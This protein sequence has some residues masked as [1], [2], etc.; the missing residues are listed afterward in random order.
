MPR[1]PLYMFEDPGWRRFGPLTTLH[2]VW[3][4]RL[5][6]Q[7]LHDL[8][9]HLVDQVP[10]GY[11]PR[12]ALQPLVALD[13]QKPT[14]E[15]RNRGD[16]LL[17]NGRAYSY[18]DKMKLRPKPKWSIW[19]DGDDVVAAL[20]PAPV[21][22]KWLSADAMRPHDYSARNLLAIWNAEKK[23]PDVQVHE[24]P[25]ALVS[26][27]W[28]MIH[29]QEEVIKGDFSRLGKGSIAGEVDF[30]VILI[31]PDGILVEPKA[32]VA[33]GA[34]LDA[35]RGPVI[36]RDGVNVL[37]GA[38]IMGPVAIDRDCLVKAGCLLYTSPSPRD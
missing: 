17:V 15:I 37:P 28:E 9:V 7:S 18:L 19:S 11:F 5:G 1:T 31:E 36:L 27:P 24:L 38:V 14:G 10:T 29:L 13:R 25:G 3:D 6:A 30:R 12:P 21:A 33:A 16:V 34:I 4:L 8:I 26:W 35:T 23:A 2:P 20:V 22:R 32:T